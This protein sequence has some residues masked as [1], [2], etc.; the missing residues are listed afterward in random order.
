[1]K[2]KDEANLCRLISSVLDHNPVSLNVGNSR[3][4]T[5]KVSNLDLL[6]HVVK[7]EETGLFRL[8][9][10][11]DTK[12]QVKGVMND[13]KEFPSTYCVTLDYKALLKY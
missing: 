12:I 10:V 7:D 11:L 3:F 8:F 4:G 13:G 5:F 6:M 9:S 2:E 1:M